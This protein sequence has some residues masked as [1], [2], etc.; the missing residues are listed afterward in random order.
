VVLLPHAR[1]RLDLADAD[2]AGRLARRFAPDFCVVLDDGA[3]LELDAGL[4]PNARVI[5]VDGR[6][7]ELR[8]EPERSPAS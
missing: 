5:G 6:V 1:R 4:P 7:G 2:A 8:S 3:Q